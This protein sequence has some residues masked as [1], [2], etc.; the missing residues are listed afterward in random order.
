MLTNKDLVE[1]LFPAPKE[2]KI[3]DEKKKEKEYIIE[4]CPFLPFYLSAYYLTSFIPELHR[5]D[6]RGFLRRTLDEFKDIYD[7]CVEMVVKE[8]KNYGFS[9][10]DLKRVRKIMKKLKLISYNF[11]NVTIKFD[12][13]ELR[14]DTL[15]LLKYAKEYYKFKN[16]QVVYNALEELE[17]ELKESEKRNW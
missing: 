6:M 13:K 15:N 10:E 1:W 2:E 17:K 14:K 16:H 8:M 7:T 9:N 12:L 11:L 4:L 3:S 5:S